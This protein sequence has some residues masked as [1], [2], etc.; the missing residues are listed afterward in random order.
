MK[1][2]TMR[3]AAMKIM[4]DPKLGPAR[5]AYFKELRGRR[6]RAKREAERAE[7][8]EARAQKEERLKALWERLGYEPEKHTAGSAV[9]SP[10]EAWM[11]EYPTGVESATTIGELRALN[12]LDRIREKATRQRLREIGI[13]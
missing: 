10:A 7:S 2:K 1:S 11:Q 13:C 5:N 6:R 3:S 4:A 12:R 8:E 9:L